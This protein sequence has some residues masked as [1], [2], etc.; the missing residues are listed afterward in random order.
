MKHRGLYIHIPF[1]VRK[2]NY[3]DFLSFP[4][5]TEGDCFSSY[6]YALQC[7]MDSRSAIFKNREIHSVFIGGGTPSLLQPSQIILLMHRIRQCF[8]LSDNA[9]ITMECNPGTLNKKKLAAMKEAGINRLSIGLQSTQADELQALGRIHTYETFLESYQMARD[10]GF[11]NIN[12]DLMSAL[13][14]QSL[15]SYRETLERVLALKPEHISAYSL[16]IEE[17]TPFFDLYNTDGHTLVAGALPLPDE[18]TERE[19]YELTKQL[20][21]EQGYERYEISNYAKAGYA[22]RHNIAYWTGGDY[23]GLGLGASSMIGNARFTNV[24]ELDIYKA[25]WSEPHDLDEEL[26]YIKGSDS[27][28][29]LTKEAQ[30]EEFMFLGL[31]MTEGI[32]I[33]NFAKTFGQE[34]SEIYSDVIDKH[35]KDGTLI[36]EGNALKFSTKGLDVANYVMSDFIL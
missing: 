9:E 31:R 22:C 16:I 34:L 8:E 6:L 23:L 3:C 17:G 15:A 33:K 20:L 35:V 21:H 13:P 29:Y 27:I 18:D 4:V 12:I 36:I 26:L 19:M 25:I 5:S 7:E 24:S 2:C 1:C 28:E 30:M 14:G 10:F 11:D 32:D